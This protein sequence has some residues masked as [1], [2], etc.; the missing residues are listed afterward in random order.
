MR[1]TRTVVVAC[2]ILPVAVILLCGLGG[3]RASAN[4]IA[5]GIASRDTQVVM[6]DVGQGDAMLVESG[7]AAVLVDTGQEGTVLLEALARH[8]ITRLDAVVLSH[9]DADHT[10][11]LSALTGVVEVSHVY[12]H[13]DLLESKDCSEVL[14]VASWVTK[15]TGAQGVR[16]G[17]EICIGSFTM[18]LLAP[19]QG[20]SSENDDSLI[21]LL[22]AYTQDG[23]TLARGLLV[24]DAES[25]AL[26]DVLDAAGDIDFYKVGHHGST[27]A[28]SDEQMARLKPELSLISVGADNDYGHPTSSTL[29]V[30][31]RGGSKV[32][33]TDLQGDVTLTFGEGVVY[34]NCQRS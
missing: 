32:L 20:G 33:R 2:S 11:A 4:L 10:G 22:C 1:K 15:G 8:G 34:A 30:L 7:D 25:E 16:P 17:D 6:L 24:G 23:K 9:K 5:P 19:Q 14:E 13:A 21:W 29:E 12:I 3:L 31:E 27:D 28:I 26:D 18:R